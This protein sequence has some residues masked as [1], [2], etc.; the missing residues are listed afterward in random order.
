MIDRI[1]PPTRRAFLVCVGAGF[2][3]LT[4][5][6]VVRAADAPPAAAP[7]PV[8]QESKEGITHAFFATGGETYFV[9]GDG[10]MSRRLISGRDG[11]VLPSGNVLLAASKS[12]QYPGGA[13]VEFDK[14]GKVVFEFKGSQSELGTVQP[15][16]GGNFMT[17]ELGPKPR[18]M[19]V[20]R[21]GKILL[22]FPSIFLYLVT[23]KKRNLK[24]Q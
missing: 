19:E 11:W 18:L 7:P 3:L 14:D 21:E 15:L 9:A 10:Q 17:V 20:N 13:V 4:L 2:A 24:R 8:G 23:L 1:A 6:S 12:G 22:E 5:S 16:E